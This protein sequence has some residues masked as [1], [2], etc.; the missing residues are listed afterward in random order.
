M[1]PFYVRSGLVWEETEL[2]AARSLVQAHEPAGAE[3][4]IVLDMPLGD[5]YG[6]HWSLSGRNTPEAGT[7]DDA[8]YLP[9]RNAL[10]A[11]KPAMWC[12]MH[13]ID[14]LALAV[15]AR[16]RLPTPPSSSSAISSRRSRS[17][18]AGACGCFGRLQSCRRRTLWNWAAI[19][20]WN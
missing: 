13:D 17:R 10:L 2:Q 19:C 6:D 9:G 15:W 12:A 7:P 3:P 20:R 4:L 18:P 1:Q 11:I 14:G 5:L 8:V 16:I